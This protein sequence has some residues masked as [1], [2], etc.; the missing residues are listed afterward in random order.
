MKKIILALLFILISVPSGIIFADTSFN[1]TYKSLE[2][3]NKVETFKNELPNET[4]KNLENIGINEISL[5]KI[6]KIKPDNALGLITAQVKD[7]FKKITK[8]IMFAIAVIIICAMFKD[9][10]PDFN[11]DFSSNIINL[12]CVLTLS[13][14]IVNPIINTMNCISNIFRLSCKLLICYIPIVTGLMLSSGQILSSYVHS[15]FM[16]GFA[17]FMA[18]ISSVFFIPVLNLLM[19]FAI[20]SSI[21]NYAN[22]FCLYLNLLKIIKII[23][24][25]LV[26]VFIGFFS[27][28]V[29][30][31]LAME[32]AGTKSLKF[33]LGSCVPVVGK[34]LGEAA[35]TIKGCINVLKSSTSLFFIISTF[36]TFL[37]SVIECTLWCLTANICSAIGESFGINNAHKLLKSTAEVMSVILVAIL[38]FLVVIIAS[39]I[40][41]MKTAEI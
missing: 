16:V 4:L 24:G 38:C 29:T 33:L 5:E 12:I 25:L 17:N 37:P 3:E 39:T 13:V 11:K 6:N 8:P 7:V 2:K 32:G 28:K 34:A 27:V 18:Q 1:D 19:A 20:V 10:S 31:N 40:I 23:L 15:T 26:T 22:L 36:V 41:V 9:F 21:S 14:L 30:V 35:S